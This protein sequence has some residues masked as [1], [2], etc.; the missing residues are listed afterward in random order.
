M[1]QWN[2]TFLFPLTVLC[3]ALSINQAFPT[4]APATACETMLPLHMGAQPQS[5][6]A[7]YGF[8]VSTPSFLNGQP[9]YVQILG[10]TYKGLLLQARSFGSPTALGFWEVPPN[11]TK[12]LQCS[13]NPQGT[14]THSNTHVKTGHTTYA[15]FPPTSGC[16]KVV[17]FVA[18]IAQ[19]HDVYWT[20][21]KSKVI[22]RNPRATCG[23]ERLLKNLSAV[24]ALS[25]LLLHLLEYF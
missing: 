3:V 22:W 21:V 10:P 6:P 19:S 7:P 15:W 9:L 12:L 25:C 4:G 24:A 1:A 23:A 17:R 2:L 18:T 5:T 16:P 20:D 13:G 14:I 8:L 11:N